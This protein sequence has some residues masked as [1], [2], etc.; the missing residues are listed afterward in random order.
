[1]NHALR[2]GTLQRRADLPK[3]GLAILD[4]DCSGLEALV[5]ARTFQQLENQIRAAVVELVEVVDFD[6]VGVAE[7]A[8]DF[9][10]TSKARE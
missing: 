10:F 6:D 7:P 8:G 4:G 3:V 5:E 9:C 1:M 2:V